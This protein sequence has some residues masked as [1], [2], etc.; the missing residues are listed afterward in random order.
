MSEML[1]DEGS[2]G[3]HGSLYASLVRAGFHGVLKLLGTA[4]DL[5]VLGIDFRQEH[6]VSLIPFKRPHE[7]YF[8]LKRG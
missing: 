8:T 4:K 7:R 1:V 2:Q 3:F 6:V 5:A